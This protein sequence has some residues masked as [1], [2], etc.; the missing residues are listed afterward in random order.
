MTAAD[1]GLLRA[2]VVAVPVLVVL[3][4]GLGVSGSRLLIAAVR[5]CP[6]TG[7]AL[8]FWGLGRGLRRVPLLRAAI[9]L[10]RLPLVALLALLALGARLP[11]LLP[12]VLL[13]VVWLSVVWLSVVLLRLAV[14]LLGLLGLLLVIGRA[15]RLL[16]VLPV[17]LRPVLRCLPLG[18]AAVRLPLVP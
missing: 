10:V 16:V 5:P 17:A 13:P 11:V 18:V 14:G 6:Q 12:V 4:P 9:G 8:A 1:L 3:F 7:L 2:S 15:V